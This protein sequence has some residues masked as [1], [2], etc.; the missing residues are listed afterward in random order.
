MPKSEDT[1]SGRL[2]PEPL[3]PG[4]ILSDAQIMEL[5]ETSG[6]ID[7]AT[8]D[9]RSLESISYDVRVG[10]KGIVGGQGKEIDLTKEHVDVAP[11]GYAA[12]ISLECVKIPRNIVVRINSKRSFSYEGIALL[13]GTQIDPGYEGHLLFGFYNASSKKA[14]LSIGQPICSLVFETLGSD[15]SHPKAPDPDLIRGDFP[16]KFIKEMANREVLSWQQLTAH[17]QKID[18]ITKDILDLQDRYHNVMEPIEKLT[19]N[20]DRVSADVDKLSA[21]IKSVGDDVSKLD[22]ATEKNAQLVAEVS[23]NVLVLVTDVTTVK[24]EVDRVHVEHVSL[25]KRISDLGERF[26]NFSALVKVF[27][28][29]TLLI[30]GGVITKYVW[31]HLP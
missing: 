8:F 30:I 10:K 20:V 25:G 17:V 21:A 5:V 28:A 7:R 2:F 24:K 18:R 15:V 29:I 26:S 19:S 6:L 22:L 23:K 12:V 14:I 4:V 27:W 16:H 31:P 3:Q 9:K 13:T 11:G 1:G